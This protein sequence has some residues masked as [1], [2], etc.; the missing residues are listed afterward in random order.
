MDARPGVICL[1]CYLSIM[2]VTDSRRSY[3][4]Y[5]FLAGSNVY[6]LSYCILDCSLF[7]CRSS[8]LYSKGEAFGFAHFV[9]ESLTCFL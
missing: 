6:L 3:A 1:L 2:T 9:A 8:F 7:L 4:L 5:D